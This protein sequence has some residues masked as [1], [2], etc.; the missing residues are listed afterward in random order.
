MAKTALKY[1]GLAVILVSLT[2]YFTVLESRT[3]ETGDLKDAVK[4]LNQLEKQRKSPQN[5]LHDYLLLNQIDSSTAFIWSNYP[6]GIVRNKKGGILFGVSYLD[7]L[8]LPNIG[9]LMIV[10]RQDTI[11]IQSLVDTLWDFR[12]KK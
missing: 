12:S 7:T 4:S 10:T 5:L 6:Q 3:A 8:N 1:I 9:I 2:A 11:P